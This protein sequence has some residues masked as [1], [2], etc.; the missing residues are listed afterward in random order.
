MREWRI[1]GGEII[2]PNGWRWRTRALLLD[3]ADQ[4]DGRG[5]LPA[6][7]QGWQIRGAKLTPRHRRFSVTPQALEQFE[8]WTRAEP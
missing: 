2:A 7:W 8:R 3:R 4:I 1:E 5:R 6:E